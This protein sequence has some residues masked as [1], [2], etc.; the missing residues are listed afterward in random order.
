MESQQPNYSQALKTIQLNCR[1]LYTKLGEIK[2]MIYLEKPHIVALSETWI[3]SNYEPRFI[4]YTCEWKNRNS[5]GGRLGLLLKNGIQYSK[6]ELHPYADGS[7]ELQ[8]V[9]I[10]M[11]NFN[12]I[13]VNIYNPN[14][15][16]SNNEMTHYISQLASMSFLEILTH[17]C[18][19]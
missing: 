3:K 11:G 1:S 2:L 5:P 7:L 6:L 19:V 15:N 16:I 14:K 12:V 9:Q 8:A 4:D 18:L 13:Y 10:H 17:F